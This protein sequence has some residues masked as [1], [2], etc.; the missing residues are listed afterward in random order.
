MI[1]KIL[2]DH[3]AEYLLNVRQRYQREQKEVRENELYDIDFTV[4]LDKSVF[5]LLGI[6]MLFLL[7][8][9]IKTNASQLYDWI[10]RHQIPEFRIVSSILFG[11]AAIV[12][13]AFAILYLLL[14][15]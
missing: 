8:L 15:F 5:Q 14:W 2:N 3:S 12:F 1:H 7:L 10:V 11:I 6:A 9:L 13:I 4:Y